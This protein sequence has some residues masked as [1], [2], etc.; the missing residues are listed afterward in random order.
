MSFYGT[1]SIGC[2]GQVYRHPID[3]LKRQNHT[4]RKYFPLDAITALIHETLCV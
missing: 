2:M 3:D 4:D 1:L